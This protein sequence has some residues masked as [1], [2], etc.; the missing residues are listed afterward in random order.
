MCYDMSR[1]TGEVTRTGET[2]LFLLQR[3]LGGEALT[4]FG[5]DIWWD[6][7]RVWSWRK[8]LVAVRDERGERM[9][10]MGWLHHGHFIWLQSNHKD[11]S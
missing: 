3:G 6:M 9:D 4:L 5:V 10:R 1:G 7:W 8:V 11:N 2:R